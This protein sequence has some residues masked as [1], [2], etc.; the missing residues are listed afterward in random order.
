MSSETDTANW[1][2]ACANCGQSETSGEKLKTCVACKI[3]KYC[4]RDCQLA[5]RSQHKD[6]CKRRAAELHEEALY[7]DYSEVKECPICMLPM[8]L[9]KNRSCF[10]LCCW[11]HI[12]NGCHYAQIQEDI[13]NGK[14]E[15]EVGTCAFCRAPHHKKGEQIGLIQKGMEKNNA[16]A[17]YMVALYHQQ[18]K[19][20][21]P[22]DVLKMIELLKKAGVLGCAKAYYD[23]GRIYDTGTGVIKDMK[24]ARHYYELAA[25]GGYI[26]AR[27]S[28][29]CFHGFYGDYERARKHFMIGARAGDEECLEMIQEGIDRGFMTKDDYTEA[30][31]AY[32]YQQEERK[33]AMRDAALLFEADPSLYFQ[34]YSK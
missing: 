25:M 19:N 4:C 2:I 31:Q 16:D 6:A 27:C 20:G 14:E 13:K 32:Q 23:L 11:K 18:G 33:S 3:V 22:R 29:G 15:K 1:M 9:G 24:K 10:K 5:H 26:N 30:L 12:C 21:Y 34:N 8:P 7:K 28:L 17:T